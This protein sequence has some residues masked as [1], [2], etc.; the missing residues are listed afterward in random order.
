MTAEPSDGEVRDLL[1]HLIDLPESER[2]RELAREREGRPSVA[3]EAERAFAE[4][5]DLLSHMPEDP[6]A[7]SA[8][9]HAGATLHP[10]VAVGLDRVRRG[11]DLAP[12]FA[13][14]SV[15][16]H[17]LLPGFSA[18]L[19][20][21]TS[22]GHYQIVRELGRGGMGVTYLARDTRFQDKPPVAIK[23]PHR[24]NY[25]A[26]ERF[27]QEAGILQRLVGQTNIVPIFLFGMNPAPFIAMEYVEGG[28]LAQV[29]AS[30]NSPWQG[31]GKA[32]E[33]AAAELVLKLA[34]ALQVA[35]GYGIFHLDLK[36]ANVLLHPQRGP[37][38]ADFSLSQ[39][40]AN[41]QDRVQ[42]LGGTPAY[43]APEQVRMDPVANPAQIDVYGLGVILYELLAGKPPFGPRAEESVSAFLRRVQTEEPPRPS[44]GVPGLSPDLEAIC[45]HCLRKTPGERYPSVE[46]LADDLQRFLDREQPSVCRWPWRRRAGSYTRRHRAGFGFSLLVAALALM[47]L[48][49]C[50]VRLYDAQQEAEREARHEREQG[51]RDLVATARKAADSGDWKLALPLYDTA[52]RYREAGDPERLGLEVERMP[53]WFLHRSRQEVAEELDRLGRYPDLPA[54]ARAQV[55]L[56]E[57]DLRMCREGR[58]P[59]ALARLRE[60]LALVALEPA[61]VLYAEALLAPTSGEALKK[62]GGLLAEHPGHYRGRVAFLGLLL[63]RGEL[64][65]LRK[66]LPLHRHDFR[67][68]PTPAMLEAGLDVL[69]KDDLRAA[70]AHIDEV[71]GRLGEERARK[72]RAF[73]AE[74]AKLL[75]A[76][77]GEEPPNP[78]DVLRLKVIIG[79]DQDVFA[80]NVPT[81]GWLTD[82]WTAAARAMAMAPF[83]LFF[84]PE[85]VLA[86]WEG[87]CADNPEA[88]FLVHRA[89]AE[90]AVAVKTEKQD[91]RKA[92]EHAARAADT[93]YRAADPHTPTLVPRSDWRYKALLVAVLID[94]SFLC[95]PGAPVEPWR[96]RRLREAVRRAATEGRAHA[97]FRAQELP[98]VVKSLA[99][100][101]KQHPAVLSAEIPH[102]L[103]VEWMLEEPDNAVPYRLRGQLALEDGHPETAWAVVT[104]W[105]AARHHPKD[106]GLDAISRKAR[107]QLGALLNRPAAPAA[108]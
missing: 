87:V 2:D 36:P 91:R 76:A 41:G 92:L 103:L 4:I 48:G 50:F 96:E 102:S 104:Q 23:L 78:L 99:G 53:G 35:H 49:T 45:L 94:A 10:L 107:E 34:R 97:D 1:F 108:P 19:A 6:A 24:F 106:S 13:P 101:A 21:G 44:T 89:T 25:D 63:V 26:V 12:R 42:L 90:M 86:M 17:E 8:V 95:T 66:Q 69:E 11:L 18:E 75:R 62:L 100:L 7:W 28:S 32:R 33:R 40:A 20:E 61:D 27:Q 29:L 70:L 58:S 39:R 51:Y 47:A 79:D 85:T 38:L 98:K 3:A 72:W 60:S 64:P 43:M 81:V 73:L 105:Y 74:L 52:A 30:G 14:P 16:P 9:I 57:G 77:A 15:R 65:E 37:L 93:A 5:M 82:P 83:V 31:G 80:L 54:R 22:F 55:C 59:A 68:D 56:Y 46:K 71:A 88:T 67:G 84:N